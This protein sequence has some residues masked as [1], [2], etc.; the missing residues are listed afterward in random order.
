MLLKA[1]VI[2]VGHHANG[3]KSSRRTFFYFLCH[4]PP[5]RFNLNLIMAMATVLLLYSHTVNLKCRTTLSVSSATS[6]KRV[7]DSLRFNSY[8]CR[9][10]WS[11][12]VSELHSNT[13][14]IKEY[15]RTNGQL[16]CHRLRLQFSHSSLH[17]GTNIDV[18]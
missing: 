4:L 13:C 3:I 2:H 11:V 8:F 7:L 15:I 1:L 14:G 16:I 5:P 6:S 17:F 9:T 10:E 12:F 18:S